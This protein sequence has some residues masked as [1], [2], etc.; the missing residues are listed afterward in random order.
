MPNSGLRHRHRALADPRPRVR[1]PSRDHGGPTGDQYALP[2]LPD[3]LRRHS[4]QALHLRA[5]VVLVAGPCAGR[6]GRFR[7]RCVV[8]GLADRGLGRC[9]RGGPLRRRGPRDVVAAVEAGLRA[10]VAAG[11]A[12]DDVRRG[13][14]ATE[15]ERV[16]DE[17]VVAVGVGSTALGASSGA[18][19][20]VASSVA[21][22]SVTGPSV[23]TAG[24]IGA[25]TAAL[26]G[27]GT[28]ATT[29][30]PPDSAST[31]KLA[32]AVEAATRAR[33]RPGRRARSGRSVRSVSGSRET[34]AAGRRSSSTTRTSRRSPML[35]KIS[36]AGFPP[37]LP[38][39]AIS[40]PF[41][42]KE[43]GASTAPS[44]IVTP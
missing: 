41:M 40:S 10:A 31:I 6:R 29:A 37:Q 14:A 34:R 17:L 33:R 19:S 9:R 25:A 43:S 15:R 7:R 1:S 5:S 32:K 38:C 11:A 2:V 3:G 27:M 23:A 39:G 12:P 13:V 26:D 20:S 24:S 4:R 18:A 36:M 30:T 44:P 35:S 22:S 8:R 42:R 21:S 28:P 16:G